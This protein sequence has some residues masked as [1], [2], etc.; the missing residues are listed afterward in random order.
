M[1]IIAGRAK[2]HHLKAPKGAPTRPTSDKVRGAIFGMIESLLLNRSNIDGEES[3]G[4]WDG[5]RVLDLY[6]G[7]GALGIE[8][9][10]RGAQHADFVEMHPAACQT[11]RENL[12]HTKLA[13]QGRVH[14][15]PV[16][17]YLARFQR[18]EPETVGYDL[19]L[20]DPPYQAAEIEEVL[21]LL[22][23]AGVIREHGWLVAAH[24]RRRALQQQIPGMQRIK[25]RQHGDT[26][27][28]IYVRDSDGIADVDDREGPGNV[29]G[30]PF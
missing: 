25:D 4:A 1:R 30:G 16:Q 24:A 6:A 11:V 19:V 28:S 14:C 3:T 9:L 27:I 23:T 5:V 8:A 13:A 20:M 10:S 26:V 17:Q 22:G 21:N 7:T 12:V 18:R 29:Q 15:V 2:G